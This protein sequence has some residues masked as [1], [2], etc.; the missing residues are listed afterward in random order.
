MLV[1]VGSRGEAA[2]GAGLKTSCCDGQGLNSYSIFQ[3]DSSSCRRGA[4]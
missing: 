3:G 2:A 1:L 4:L